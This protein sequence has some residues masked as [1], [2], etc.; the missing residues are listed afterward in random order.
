MTHKLQPFVTLKVL[1]S[2]MSIKFILNSNK[3]L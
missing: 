3:N 1:F 2:K